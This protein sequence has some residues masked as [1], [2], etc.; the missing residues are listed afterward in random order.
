MPVLGARAPRS[1]M[2]RMV[3]D[4]CSRSAN[5]IAAKCPPPRSGG[6]GFV[7]VHENRVVKCSDKQ[8]TWFEG[9]TL[10]GRTPFTQTL[11]G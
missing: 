9:E 5:R 1:E 3:A 10:E 7:D 8:P 4:I 6:P 11:S 2:T